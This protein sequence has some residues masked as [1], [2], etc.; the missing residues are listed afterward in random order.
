MVGSTP[1]GFEEEIRF[2]ES[3]LAGHYLV[4]I[5]S[6]YLGGETTT[7]EADDLRTDLFFGAN[8]EYFSEDQLLDGAL[9]D[10]D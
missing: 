10:T 2:A 9:C 3:T 1:P 6:S 5:D 7:F 8:N 4:I